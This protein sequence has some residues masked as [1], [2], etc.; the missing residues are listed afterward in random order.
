MKSEVAGRPQDL[1]PSR[2]YTFYHQQDTERA[3]DGGG[4]LLTY[5]A[6]GGT[7]EA[8]LKIG[9]EVVAALKAAGLQPVWDGTVRKRIGVPLEWQRRR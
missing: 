5:G 7:E 4:V 8:S 1:P 9:H 6:T 2:G 3:V